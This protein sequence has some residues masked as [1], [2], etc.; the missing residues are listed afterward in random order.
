MLKYT[1]TSIKQ[2]P[3]EKKTDVVEFVR[4]KLK[5]TGHVTSLK[6]NRCTYKTTFWFTE[7]KNRRK[8]R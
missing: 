6:D 1:T 2:K 8:G 3:N 7:H 4:Q 5:L